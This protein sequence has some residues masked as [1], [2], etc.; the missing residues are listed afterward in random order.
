[1]LAAP[2]ASCAMVE[3]TR[4]RNYRH[5]RTCRRS[6]RNGFRLI[7]CSPR[8]P[9]FSSH[10]RRRKDFRRLDPSVGGSGPHV[11]AVRSCHARQS[12][13]KRPSHPNPTFVTIA[14]RPSCES[15]CVEIKHKFL[16]NGRRNLDEKDVDQ[17]IGLKGLA[18]LVFRR[19][20]KFCPSPTARARATS[21]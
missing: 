5:R 19:R 18:K 12:W 11:F 6:L 4:V 15:G 20:R 13:P 8:C 3:S 7:S 14:K 2:A 10:R 9:G 17:P 21:L 16:K 1:M